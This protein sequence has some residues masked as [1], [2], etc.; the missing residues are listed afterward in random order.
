MNAGPAESGFSED[1]DASFRPARRESDAYT[2]LLTRTREMDADQRVLRDEW[3]AGLS[4]RNKEELLFELEVLLKASACFA[5]PRNHPGPARRVPIVAQDFREAAVVLKDGLT[6]AT[7]IIRIL[8][9]SRDRVYVFHR[10]LET[11]LPE[12][13]QATTLGREWASQAHPEEALIALRQSLTQTVTVLEGLLR[14]PRVPFRIFYA[15]A[16][17]AER[18]IAQNAFFNPLRALEFRP[19]FDTLKS[20][21]LLSALGKV[22]PGKASELVTLTV[23]SLA[24]QLHYLRLLARIS[25][26]QRELTAAR[27]YL[28]ASVMFSDARALSEHLLR[29]GGPS[30]SGAFGRGLLE[31]PRTEIVAR[32][33]DLSSLADL[34]SDVRSAL[35]SIAGGLRLEMRRVFAFGL[36]PVDTLPTDQALREAMEWTVSSV[37]PALQHWITSLMRATGTPV[38][39]EDAFGDRSAQRDVQE[40]LRRDAWMFAQILRG[41]QVKAGSTELSDTWPAPAQ[42]HY[43]KQFLA[44]FNAL[45]LPL[46]GVSTYPRARPLRAAMTRLETGDILDAGTL[47]R[48]IEE[49][50]AFREHLDHLFDV[51]SASDVL[52]SAPFDRK[53]AAES[54]RAYLRTPAP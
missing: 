51:I 3:Y 18:E 45:G 41:F 4:V 43:V 19:E 40:R 33:G 25:A 47:A 34:F 32:R 31:V 14:A 23:L 2:D 46:V 20:T 6:R 11:V 29:T 42:P 27:L 21:A 36:P 5:N 7:Q 50:A 28:V 35:H 22:P 15:T 30:L 38:A 37:R 17:I 9:G 54:L 8:L 24:R 49:S 39:D 53:E 16:A 44:Y 13:A 48:T 26:E 52:S 10:Y 1:D 12:A